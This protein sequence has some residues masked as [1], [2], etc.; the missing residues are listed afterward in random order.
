MT[1]TE[2]KRVLII[3]SLNLYL[4]AYIMDPSLTMQGEPCGGIKGSLKILQKLVRDSKPDEIIFV[5]DGPNGSR[6]RKALN[7]DYKAGRKPIRLNRSV[8]NLTDEQEIQNKV[9]QQMRLMEYLNEMP[10]MQIII[11]EVEADDV[12]SYITQMSYYRGWQKVIVSNDKD[13]Y[14]LCDGETV[15]F[16]PV[17]KTV[18]NKKRIVEE[19]GVHPRNMALARALVGDASDN[20][21]GIKSVGFKTIQRRL[22]F[23]A[24]DKDYTIDDIVSY[25]EKTEKKLKFHDNILEG[26]ETIAHNYKMM[27]LY[28]PLLSTQSKDFVK[29]SIEN[30]DCNFNKIEIIKKMRDDGFGELNWKDLELHLNKIHSVC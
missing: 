19:L 24:A 14:Q 6:K 17:S 30:F 27:Q 26:Q 8:K 5:W 16:R 9:W 25:C 23:L 1:D 7:K 20:L 10:I 13:F 18:Y 2:Q 4:R 21:P 29:N 11:P 28:S 15:V 12:I 22:G 3:D